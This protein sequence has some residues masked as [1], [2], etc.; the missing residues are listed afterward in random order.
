M[1]ELAAAMSCS[2]E[3]ENESVSSEASGSE[4]LQELEEQCEVLEGRLASLSVQDPNETEDASFTRVVEISTITVQLEELQM[5]LVAARSLN[6]V[7]QGRTSRQV[8]TKSPG[9]FDASARRPRPSLIEKFS[10]GFW[11]S[12]STGSRRSSSPV[13]LGDL[14]PELDSEQ[15]SVPPEITEDVLAEF[16][17]LSAR[18][19]SSMSEQQ[20]ASHVLRLSELDL[21]LRASEMALSEARDQSLPTQSAA[22]QAQQDLD[23][24]GVRISDWPLPLGLE[25]PTT[26]MEHQLEILHNTLQ[27]RL[28]ESQQSIEAQLMERLDSL[29]RQRDNLEDRVAETRRG[30]SD[31]EAGAEA[32][33]ERLQHRTERRRREEATRLERERE[34]REQAERARRETEELRQRHSREEDATRAAFAQAAASGS[35]GGATTFGGIGDLRMCRRCGYGPIENVACAD[36]TAHNNTAT[37]YRGR[38]VASQRNPNHCPHCNWFDSDWRRWPYWDGTYGVHR[39]DR[40]NKER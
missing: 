17:E 7:N 10:R 19:L 12:L 25:Y 23:A 26:R 11:R 35:N 14:S 31:A 18:N 20:Q 22:L 27:L 40:R 33:E 30:L 8:P 13:N 5:R 36:L 38:I 32:E 6:S 21:K 34:L 4:E 9:A 2:V 37:T 24:I 1:T 15:S 29:T 16:L 3:T 28:V 39:T